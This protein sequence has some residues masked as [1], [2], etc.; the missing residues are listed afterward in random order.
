[1]SDGY[2]NGPKTKSIQQH[3]RMDVNS[4][5]MDNHFDLT[6]MILF[7]LNIKLELLCFRFQ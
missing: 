4:T 3:S 5:N 1:M 6:K 7:T 2:I